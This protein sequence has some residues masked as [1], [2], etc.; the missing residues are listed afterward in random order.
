[1]KHE[2]R[3]NYFDVWKNI[4]LPKKHQASTAPQQLIVLPHHGPNSGLAKT[5]KASEKE[6][7]FATVLP[8]LLFYHTT[9]E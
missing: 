3:Q 1:L 4:L 7:N 8:H 9:R 6:M 5:N 2:T